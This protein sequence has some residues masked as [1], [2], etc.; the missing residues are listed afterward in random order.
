M[1]VKSVQYYNIYIILSDQCCTHFE[2]T[3]TGDFMQYPCTD[4]K[5]QH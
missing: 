4:N 2:T 3:A 1:T 5:M